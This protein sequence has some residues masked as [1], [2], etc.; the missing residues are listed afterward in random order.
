MVA[1]SPLRSNAMRAPRYVAV[2]QPG[3]L[4]YVAIRDGVW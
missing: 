2:Y 1:M 3:V 4:T